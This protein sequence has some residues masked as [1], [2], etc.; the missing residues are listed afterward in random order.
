MSRGFKITPVVLSNISTV[1]LIFKILKSLAAA[2][3][4]SPSSFTN[5]NAWVIANVLIMIAENV[6]NKDLIMINFKIRYF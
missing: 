2:I 4:A 6:F 3:L 5:G 1:F